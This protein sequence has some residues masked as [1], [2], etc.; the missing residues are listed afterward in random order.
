MVP[1]TH[2]FFDLNRETSFDDKKPPK[3]C[4]TRKQASIA[5]SWRSEHVHPGC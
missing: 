4:W 2:S 5:N 1:L 3:A